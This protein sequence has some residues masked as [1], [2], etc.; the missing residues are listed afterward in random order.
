MLE[1]RAAGD[2]RV[3]LNYIQQVNGS[4]STSQRSSQITKMVKKLFELF[5]CHPFIFLNY[6]CDINEQLNKL[7]LNI[8]KIYPVCFRH[9]LHVYI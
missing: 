3:I 6:F 9:I 2:R 7:T 4:V 8:F 1:M 5:H